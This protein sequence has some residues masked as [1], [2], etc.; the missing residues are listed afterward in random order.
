MITLADFLFCSLIPIQAIELQENNNQPYPFNSLA[1]KLTG[2]ASLLNMFASSFFLTWM[3]VYRAKRLIAICRATGQGSGKG[4]GRNG[5]G[6]N[7]GNSTTR[8]S[9]CLAKLR[10]Q[11]DRYLIA[12]SIW[13]L[14]S[15][16]ASQALFFRKVQQEGLCHQIKSRPPPDLNSA[17]FDDQTVLHQCCIR[18]H[19]NAMNETRND[20]EFFLALSAYLDYSMSIIDNEQCVW[21]FK[22]GYFSAI[23]VIPSLYTGYAG[24][25]VL[26]MVRNPFP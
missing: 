5:G 18:I 20:W 12:V 15:L 3:A 25:G 21:D 8:H 6:L 7:F 11:D 4:Q 13:L 17:N 1:C 10:G 16:L 14:S 24:Q 22:G 9:G 26:K 2:F 23:L 19:P